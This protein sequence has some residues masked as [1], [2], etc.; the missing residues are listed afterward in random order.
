MYFYF[1]PIV[2]I[3]DAHFVLHLTVFWQVEPGLSLPSAKVVHEMS[4]RDIIDR[5]IPQCLESNVKVVAL[6][7]GEGLM[8]H[9]ADIIF[10][11]LGKS[12][13]RWCLDSNL[14]LCTQHIESLEKIL[15]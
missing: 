11:E 13:L 14:M 6:S 4:T 12:N 8:R 7:G 1:L 10:C 5:V 9:D 2:V 15:S 3:C